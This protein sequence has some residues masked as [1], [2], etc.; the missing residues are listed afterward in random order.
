LNG[1]ILEDMC[2]IY[3]NICKLKCSTFTESESCR[4]DDCFWLYNGEE[5]SC[6]EKD[7]ELLGCSDVKRSDQCPSSNV[8]SL[9]EKKCIWALNACYDVKNTCESITENRDVCETSGAAV[10]TNGGIS[11]VWGKDS[12]GSGICAEKNSL[13]C[14]DYV[15]ELGCTWSWT[16]DITLKTV[17]KWDAVFKCT[18][19][20]ECGGLKGEGLTCESYKSQKGQCFFNGDGIITTK[21]K[22]CSDSADFVNCNQFTILSVCTYANKNLFTKLPGSLQIPCVWN[23]NNNSCKAQEETSV[24]IVCNTWYNVLYFFFVIN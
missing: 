11:C 23:A 5:G 15:R 18:D 1:T 16:D 4:S 10:G 13:S 7:D 3:N 19:S 2:K 22:T 24:N 20:P 14:D 17:C 9:K 6:E 12:L 8:N 21:G